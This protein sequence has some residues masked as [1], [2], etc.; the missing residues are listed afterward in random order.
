M[1]LSLADI[2]LN[3]ILEV[4]HGS[5]SYGTATP[6]SD[7]DYKGI[8]ILPYK[9]YWFGVSKF[10]QKDNEW[11]DSENNP[12]DKVIYHLPKFIDL[13]RASNPNILEVLYTDRCNIVSETQEGVILR[14]N[15]DLFLSKRCVSSYLGYAQSQIIRLKN[16]FHWLT[17][18][19]EEPKKEDYFHRKIL[20]IGPLGLSLSYNAKIIRIFDQREEPT[21]L[22]HKIEIESFDEKGYD[23]AKKSFSNFETWRKNRNPERAAL[24]AVHGF[25]L[26]FAYH[27]KRL[28]DT[29]IEI[30]KEGEVIVKRPNASELMDI[31]NGKWSFQKLMDYIEIAKLEIKSLEQTSSLKNEPDNNKIDELQISLIEEYIKRIGL[32]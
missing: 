21:G 14:Q 5:Q 2:K 20:D 7:T 11:T 18:N 6:E 1:N 27:L 31:R 8:C 13:A 4:I 26:K 29:C 9:R 30:L 22:W 28:L 3:T 15:R 25:D 17:K 10:E 23:G 32:T 19:V 16:H 12:V 24:E